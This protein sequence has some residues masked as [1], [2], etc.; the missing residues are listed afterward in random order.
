MTLILCKVRYSP[1]A[2]AHLAYWG[3]TVG[4][5]ATPAELIAALNARPDRDT[6]QFQ[7]F[8]VAQ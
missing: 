5:F 8:R 1:N 7:A 2:P 6:E 4:T 3:E